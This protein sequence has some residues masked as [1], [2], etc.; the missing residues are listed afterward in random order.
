MFY[1]AL[2]TLE[3]LSEELIFPDPIS[4]ELGIIGMHSCTEQLPRILD[5]QVTGENK[6]VLMA[7]V[8]E[9]KT[10]WSV[11]AALGSN[12]NSSLINSSRLHTSS[13]KIILLKYSI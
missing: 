4:S 11:V 2:R 1:I 7:F 10:I 9:T 12:L 3:S 5:V 6:R 13:D 8:C